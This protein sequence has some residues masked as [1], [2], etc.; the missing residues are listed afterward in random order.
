MDIVNEYLKAHVVASRQ[1]LMVV[2]SPIVCNDGFVM[3]VQASD[4]HYC[5]PRLSNA[6]PY[7]HFEVGYPTPSE[8]LF[9]GYQPVVCDDD[10]HPRIFGNVPLEV[11]LKVIEKHG[12]I[13]D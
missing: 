2:S 10:E 1:E 9:A 4:F 11:V 12:G 8:E 7:T 3:S 13:R 5:T 6:Y